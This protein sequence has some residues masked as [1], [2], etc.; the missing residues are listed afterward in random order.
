[1]SR[2]PRLKDVSAAIPDI[3]E[4]ISQRRRAALSH[5]IAFHRRNGPTPDDITVRTRLPRLWA[6]RLSIN[7]EGHDRSS[8]DIMPTRSGLNELP[9]QDGACFPKV[10][11]CPQPHV[12]APGIRGQSVPMARRSKTSRR[13]LDSLTARCRSGGRGVGHDRALPPKAKS[14]TSC[15]GRAV[16]PPHLDRYY[17]SS[18]REGFGSILCPLGGSR[19]GHKRW[20]TDLAGADGGRF[21]PV[22]RV[23]MS[24][25][26]NPSRRGQSVAPE[27][28][29]SMGE[30][31]LSSGIELFDSFT[32][33]NFNL[34]VAA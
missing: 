32:L 8:S 27:R 13:M 18:W 2:Y 26:P 7:P 21:D 31:Q 10:R 5:D 22:C 20:R 4:R 9:P 17:P 34:P 24:G 23:S 11:S 3:E 30:Q 6:F 19:T 28:C 15:G 14:P 33:S 16:P 12:G 29:S 1:M 25:G